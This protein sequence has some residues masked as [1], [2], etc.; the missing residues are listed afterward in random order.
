[1]ADSAKQA[2]SAPMKPDAPRGQ[3]AAS[4][5]AGNSGFRIAR[6]VD[7]GKADGAAA[8]GQASANSTAADGFKSDCCIRWLRQTSTG[9]ENRLYRCERE[10]VRSE[11]AGAPS[12]TLF[13]NDVDLTF[14]MTAGSSN[15]AL[16]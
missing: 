4:L 10:P 3:E 2:D 9:L 12:L 1:L 8:V 5:A 16:L 11:A 7:M 14:H 15:V 6:D 13:D